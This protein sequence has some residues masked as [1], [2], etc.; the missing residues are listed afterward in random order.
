MKLINL[1][2]SKIKIAT[3]SGKYIDLPSEG[4]AKVQTVRNPSS[5]KIE[6][7]GETIRTN[8]NTVGLK[9][10]GLP[11]FQEG[12]Y[13]IVPALTYNALKNSR[14]DL[15]TID[16]PERDSSN[17]VMVVRSIAQVVS[18]QDDSALLFVDRTIRNMSAKIDDPSLVDMAVNAL[19]KIG[20]MI[21]TNK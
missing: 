20:K 8:I 21:S 5:V 17:G 15:F 1:T 7:N 2:A 12:V 19:S 3:K 11:E 6:I 16:E 14:T 9:V 10:S 18:S 4:V 13:Y